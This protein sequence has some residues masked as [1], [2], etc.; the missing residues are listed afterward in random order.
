MRAVRIIGKK[1]DSQHLALPRSEEKMDESNPTQ[2]H[3]SPAVKATPEPTPLSWR[4]ALVLV[5]L[6]TLI[7]AGTAGVLPGESESVR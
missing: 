7:N 2:L 6:V 4:L 1:R 5:I 3:L